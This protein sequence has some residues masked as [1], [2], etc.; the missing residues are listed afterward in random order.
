M[1]GFTLKTNNTIIRFRYYLGEAPTTCAAF[2]A[3]L[4]FTRSFMHA[5]VSGQEIWTDYGL[6]LDIIQENSSVFTTPGEVVLGPV[7]PA[8]I[9]TADA[10]GI[11]YGE[12][13]GLDACNIFACVYEEDT[14]L[15]I[16]LGEQIW[17]QGMQ[18]LR[19]ERFT[20]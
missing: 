1:T 15:L 5:R 2:A 6:G 10:L 16:G 9:K 13:K 8:R 11:Y 18:E 3:A 12:G 19:F 4:P 17:K 14:E 7:K 20:D